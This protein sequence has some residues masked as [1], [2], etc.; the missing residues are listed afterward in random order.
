MLMP[1]SQKPIEYQ[2]CEKGKR[3]GEMKKTALMM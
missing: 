1:Y 2:S 3:K